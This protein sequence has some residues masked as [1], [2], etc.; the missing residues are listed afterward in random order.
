MVT[1]LELELEFQADNAADMDLLK[2]MKRARY[3]SR[4]GKVL[5]FS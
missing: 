4:A 5:P 2:R 1:C 3:M